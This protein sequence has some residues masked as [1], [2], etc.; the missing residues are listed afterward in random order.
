[1]DTKLVHNQV[2]INHMAGE[3]QQVAYSDSA[4][5]SSAIPSNA[6]GV[7]L[8]STTDCFVRIGATAQANVDFPLPAFTMVLMPVRGGEIVSAIQMSAPGTLHVAPVK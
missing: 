2:Y 8:W 3:T 7:V 6:H 1:M 5:S 4:A